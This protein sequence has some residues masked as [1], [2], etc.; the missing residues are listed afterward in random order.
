MIHRLEDKLYSEQHHQFPVIDFEKNDLLTGLEWLDI[1]HKAIVNKTPLLL[2][3]QSF[4]A[5]TAGDFVFYPYLLK[6][7]RNRWFLLGMK[8]KTNE[9]LT[10]ALDRIVDVTPQP[11]KPFK[12]L[13]GFHPQE[14]FK[15]IVGVTRNAGHRPVR[16]VFDASHSQAP[17]I[18]TKPIHHS[19][20]V[21][22]EGRGFTR[23]S[24]ELILN[25]ELERELMGFGEGVKVIS[26]ASLVTRIKKRIEMMRRQYQNDI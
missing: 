12:E 21:L 4:K 11:E 19:Q 9:L 3:Y 24:L 16:V 5:R 1:L 14:Y 6:E 20:Q 13:P 23:F 15:S 7:Y 2:Q 26:P 10:L 22:E 17:Y 8:H 18:K 25:Y